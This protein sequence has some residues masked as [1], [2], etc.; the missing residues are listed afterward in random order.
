M[1]CA[2]RSCALCQGFSGGG[3][4]GS[5][6]CCALAVL[7]PAEPGAAEGLP[8]PVARLLL[9]KGRA[10][11]LLFAAGLQSRQPELAGKSPSSLYGSPRPPVLLRNW[12]VPRGSALSWLQ[13][14]SATP[15]TGQLGLTVFG[16]CAV[17]RAVNPQHK[18]VPWQH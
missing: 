7:Q 14:L 9:G 1:L 8:V 3:R 16:S 15:G 18:R 13:L 10:A 11:L 17:S 12:R 2:A 4:A 6:G 5:C